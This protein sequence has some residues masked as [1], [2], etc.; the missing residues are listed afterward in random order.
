MI[1]NDDLKMFLTGAYDD[2]NKDALQANVEGLKENAVYRNSIFT[3]FFNPENMKTNATYD[4]TV[5]LEMKS[6]NSMLRRFKKK[7][8]VARRGRNRSPPISQETS[9]TIVCGLILA[10]VGYVLYLM[11]IVLI[12][13]LLII[14]LIVFVIIYLGVKIFKE[15]F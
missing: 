9:T 1:S 13:K 5:F 4:T 2:S 3:S 11:G 12:I 14:V 7:S 6:S 8:S 10:G 15:I